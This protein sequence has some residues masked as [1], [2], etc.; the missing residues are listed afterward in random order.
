VCPTSIGHIPGNTDPDRVPDN[1]CAYNLVSLAYKDRFPR[2]AGPLAFLSGRAPVPRFLR[3][4]RALA[5]AR[6]R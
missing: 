4:L 6:A 5:T 2:Q 3:E 1:L